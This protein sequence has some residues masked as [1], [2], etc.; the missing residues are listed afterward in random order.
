MDNIEGDQKMKAKEE[1]SRKLCLSCGAEIDPEDFYCPHCGVE[2]KENSD[3]LKRYGVEADIEEYDL[4]VIDGHI[5]VNK[6]LEEL[7]VQSYEEMFQSLQDLDQLKTQKRQWIEQMIILSILTI[8]IA[9]SAIVIITPAS[10]QIKIMVSLGLFLFLTLAAFIIH[11]TKQ[12]RMGDLNF[13]FSYDLKEALVEEAKAKNIPEDMQL[14]WIEQ[15]HKEVMKIYKKG[16]Q[17]IRK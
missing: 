17:P 4:A 7:E 14:Q 16:K 11:Q 10:L 15:Q 1:I 8:P 9:Y 12:T 5:E 6:P 2:L 3:F 13:A